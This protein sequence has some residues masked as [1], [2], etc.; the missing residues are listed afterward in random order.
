MT[1]MAYWQIDKLTFMA[2]WQTDTPFFWDVL[3]EMAWQWLELKEESI[4][5]KENKV[6]GRLL[7]LLLDVAGS[8][9]GGLVNRST[10][11]LDDR[12]TGQLKPTSF[13]WHTW[14]E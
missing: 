9:V 10:S 13:E 7:A 4:K 11:L 3:N 6:I 2:Y 5:V 12:P 1:F 14:H 8:E